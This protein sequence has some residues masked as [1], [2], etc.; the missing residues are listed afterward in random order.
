M[1][2]KLLFALLLLVMLS[3]S[4]SADVV[5]PYLVQPDKVPIFG[6]H[7]VVDASSATDPDNDIINSTYFEAQIAYMNNTLGCHFIT[8]ERLASYANNRSKIPS[9]TCV[10]TLDDGRLNQYQNAVPILLKYN[11]PASFFP[12]FMYANESTNG[13][14]TYTSRMNFTVLQNLTSMGFE[15]GSHGMNHIVLDDTATYDTDV[16]E[17]NGSK[18]AWAEKGFTIKTIAWPYSAVNTNA[19]DVANLSGLIGGRYGAVS[20][21]YGFMATTLS[22]LFNT[23]NL[24]SYNS[25]QPNYWYLLN[26]V[27]PEGKTLAD[28]YMNGSTLT[29]PWT[30]FEDAY[31]ITNDTDGDV[32][33]SIF[34]S[35]P[36]TNTSYRYLKLSD[37]SDVILVQFATKQADTLMIETISTSGSTGSGGNYSKMNLYNHYVD[38]VKYTQY[39]CDYASYPTY[40]DQN[41]ATDG[42]YY[43]PV[44]IYINSTPL[45]AGV[46][47][48]TIEARGSILR[49]DKFTVLSTTDQTFYDDMSVKEIVSLACTSSAECSSGYCVDG[50][51]CSSSCGGTCETCKEQYAPI[52]WCHQNAA[53]I[54]STC[55]GLS[56]GAYSDGE[57]TPVYINYTKP[58]N[59]M[60][61]SVWQISN[62][63]GW[64]GNLSIV[65]DCWNYHNDMLELYRSFASMDM[66]YYLYWSCFNG[67]EWV[68]LG[69]NEG[70]SSIVSQFD[71]SMWWNISTITNSTTNGSCSYI[72]TNSDVDNECPGSF[73]TCAGLTC[74]GAGACNYLSGSPCRNAAGTCDS[75]ETCPGDSFSCPA[76]TKLPA[77]EVSCT[78]CTRCDGVNNDC[79]NSFN[80]LQDTEG[81]NICM[82]TCKVCSSGT[83]SNQASGQDLFNQCYMLGCDGS[84]ACNTGVVITSYSATPTVTDSGASIT[85]SSTA[86]NISTPMDKIWVSYGLVNPDT[87]INITSGVNG[88]NTQTWSSGSITPAVYITRVCVNSTEGYSG[89]SSNT[90][91]LWFTATTIPPTSYSVENTSNIFGTPVRSCFN[92]CLNL[93]MWNCGVCPFKT[94]WGEG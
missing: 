55:G 23:T 61:N 5:Y 33:T 27:K 73:G 3:V 9:N 56:T 90:V 45:S 42:A 19:T 64:A 36:P 43:C 7:E 93:D 78:V 69:V 77:G 91:N 70:G 20:P 53:N 66:K 18:N 28:F 81:S 46:H 75:A 25:T 67:T 94:A 35:T 32:I 50:V 92:Y 10:V 86:V 37:I 38:G 47:N 60:N 76:D 14:T 41:N 34:P 74:N 89:C 58:T 57:F 49:L 15:I 51:C 82:S 31:L 83:C 48:Y 30:Q 44:C 26:Y 24:G 52:G 85:F 59:A 80:N 40:C 71:E 13:N 39:A 1:M 79:Q 22:P 87:I 29:N 62:T 63:T 88:S 11:V 65:S 8:F 72:A 17:I 2:R 68:G 54:S 84:A 4:V 16:L 6:Y 12:P 21:G